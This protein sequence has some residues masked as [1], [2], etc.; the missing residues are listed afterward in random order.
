MAETKVQLLR[1]TQHP[2]TSLSYSLK[3]LLPYTNPSSSSDIIAKSVPAS[4]YEWHVSNAS[5]LAGQV[6]LHAQVEDQDWYTIAI[7][8][9][10]G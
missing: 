2:H 3:T 9:V 1:P 8:E 6:S 10:L 7:H 5:S 4:G